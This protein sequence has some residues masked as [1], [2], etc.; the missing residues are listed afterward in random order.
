MPLLT[1]GAVDG[2]WGWLK[3]QP[4]RAALLYRPWLPWL[5]AG[6]T[7]A[8]ALLRNLPGPVGTWLAP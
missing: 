4:R 2:V 1:V 3:G 7:V 8:F 5:V 6:L